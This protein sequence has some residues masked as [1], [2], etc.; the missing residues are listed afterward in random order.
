MSGG[1]MVKKIKIPSFFPSQKFTNV[2][3]L[4]Y[5]CGEIKIG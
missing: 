2:Q 3:F 5:L 4:L 1:G